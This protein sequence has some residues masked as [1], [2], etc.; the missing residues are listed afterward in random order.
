MAVGAEMTSSRFSGQ[1]SVL[2][3]LHVI[4]CAVYSARQ[5]QQ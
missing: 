3:T 4:K 1:Q 2:S 5:W